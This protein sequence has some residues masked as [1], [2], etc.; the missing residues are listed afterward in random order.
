MRPRFQADENL[1]VKIVNGILRREAAID[2]RTAAVAKLL[3][4]SDMDVLAVAARSGRILVSHDQRT[5]PDDFRAFTGKSESAGLLI[6]SQRLDVRQAIDQIVLV[7][8]AS[9]AEEW[10]NRMVYLPL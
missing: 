7:W 2:F 1:N 3:G 6:V 5:L 9:E 8:A 10:I 4:L